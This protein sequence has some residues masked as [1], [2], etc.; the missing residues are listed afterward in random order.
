MNDRT[1]TWGPPPEDDV[2]RETSAP[3]GRD[4]SRETF[5]TPAR[6]V[7]R[8]TSRRDPRPKTLSPEAYWAAVAL[9]VLDWIIAKIA[10]VYLLTGGSK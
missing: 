2:S 7:S 5:A 4:V 10:V 1:T 6:H 3:R 9:I 8:E